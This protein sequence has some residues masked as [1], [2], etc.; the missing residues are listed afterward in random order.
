MNKNISENYYSPHRCKISE[1]LVNNVS[2]I[3]KAETAEIR[4]KIGARIQS[5]EFIFRKAMEHLKVSPKNISQERGIYCYAN[6]QRFRT[7]Y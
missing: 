6:L 3:T 1:L 2:E 7:P 4:R 5:H